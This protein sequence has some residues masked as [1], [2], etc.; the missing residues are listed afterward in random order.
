[1]CEEANGDYNVPLKVPIGKDEGCIIILYIR[2]LQPAGR[3]RPSGEFYAAREG[4]FTKYNA[5]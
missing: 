3:I 5:L 1:M 2:D 4:Y